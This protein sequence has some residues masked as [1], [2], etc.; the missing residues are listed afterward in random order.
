VHPQVL[1]SR[2]DYAHYQG[3]EAQTE[4]RPKDLKET[5]EAASAEYRQLL[6]ERRRKQIIGNPREGLKQALLF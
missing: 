1:L 2:N 3:Y 5:A 6:F 4:L